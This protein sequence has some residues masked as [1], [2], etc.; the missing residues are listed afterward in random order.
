M[1]DATVS[2]RTARVERRCGT[3]RG[4]IRPGDRYLRHVAFPG[5]VIT[6][7]RPWVAAECVSCACTL[8]DTAPVIAGACG[9][10]CCGAEPCAL[11]AQ[12]WRRRAD[13]RCRSCPDSEGQGGAQ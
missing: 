10:Y 13:H 9:S 4:L 11:P 7:R 1:I 2:Y 8:D 3:C 6:G 5:E 12:H